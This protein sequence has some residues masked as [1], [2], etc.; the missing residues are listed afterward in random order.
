M[1]ALL[2]AACNKDGGQPER[3]VSAERR[4]APPPEAAKPA[5]S[6]CSAARRPNDP[7]NL[8]ELPAKAG[9][10]CL[11]PEGNDHGF[12]E[13]AKGPLEGIC[14]LFDGE[15]GL[16]Q[17]LGV[18]RVVEARYVDGGGSKATID[19]RL[20]RFG[21]PEQALAMFTKRAVG[22]GDPAH[23]DAPKPLAAG[24]MAALGIGNAYLWRG[25]ELAEITYNDADASAAQ[26]A[27]K[28]GEL[29]PGLAKEMGG[30][31]PGA[32]ELPT[33][34]KLLPSEGRLPI[35]VSYEAADA[36][37]PGV[38]GGAF[39]YYKDGD[40][41]WRV[42]ALA[43]KDEPQAK[44]RWKTL[45]SGGHE[46]KKAGGVLLLLGQPKAEWLVARAGA[47]IVGIGDEV[48]V[49]REG[50]TPDEHGKVCL[51]IDDKRARL[52]ELV[53]K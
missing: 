12:G 43:A 53:A 30:M 52:K 34:V 47:T 1:I 19:V 3:A 27:A 28:T 21:S 37:V 2:A 48:L 9:A 8:T 35:G 36:L 11:D 4:G 6:A 32:L 17:K 38:G 10:F 29:L 39:G 13:G 40:K 41:R 49:L 18:K 15:C 33:A 51:S 31:M 45:S 50:M 20:S 42:L 5:A 26:I 46:D 24:G 16:Y 7:S 23:P 14:D 44:D 25:A 22:G